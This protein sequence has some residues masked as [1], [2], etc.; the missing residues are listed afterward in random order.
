MNDFTNAGVFIANPGFNYKRPRAFCVCGVARSGTSSVASGL[1]AA[2]IPMG[3]NL[4]NVKED[5]DFRKSLENNDP[6]YFTKYLR[7]RLADPSRPADLPIG[8]K[9]PS[10]YKSIN[11]LSKTNDLCIIVVTRDPV[12]VAIR[13][14]ESM[15]VPFSTAL[16]EAISAFRELERNIKQVTGES[17]SSRII[18]VS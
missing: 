12:S 13:N 6:E 17:T 9:Y 2:G 4:S 3:R 10:A 1:E 16:D 7:S 18:F 11:V 8:F 14:T 5:I 15:F